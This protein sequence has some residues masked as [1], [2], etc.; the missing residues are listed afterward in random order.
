GAADRRARRPLRTGPVARGEPADRGA[1]P[2]GTGGVR[3]QPAAD[4]AHPVEVDALLLRAGGDRGGNAG[5]ERGAGR[6]G[7]PAAA[8][9][10]GGA[11]RRRGE[12]RA[13]SPRGGEVVRGQEQLV[14]ALALRGA[15]GRATG[16][17]AEQPAD[18]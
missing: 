10:P 17:A 6:G 8:L 14:T 7:R 11:G 9:G 5:H 13:G 18:V 1:R 2:R 4:G 15:V 16:S 3:P 12:R